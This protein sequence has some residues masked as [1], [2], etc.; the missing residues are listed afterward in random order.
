MSDRIAI[1]QNGKLRCCG[2]PFYL[3]QHFS[4]GYKITLVK[5]KPFS[6]TELK[7][8]I[9]KHVGADEYRIESEIAAELRLSISSKR[10]QSLSELLIELDEAKAAI[11]ID[12]YGIGS[13]D[14]EEVFLK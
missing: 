12:S 6:M 3:K 9:L 1:M 2:S 14:I 13:P 10:I 5:K 11:G 4:V 8:I 7:R